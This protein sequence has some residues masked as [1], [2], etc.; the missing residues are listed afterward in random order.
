MISQ[1]FGSFSEWTYVYSICKKE[2]R[3]IVGFCWR[4]LQFE[5]NKFI[6]DSASKRLSDP[7][8]TMEKPFLKKRG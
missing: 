6:I 4:Y 1:L 3:Q 2:G 5:E 7:N 8:G